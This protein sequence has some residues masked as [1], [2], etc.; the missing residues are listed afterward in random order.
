MSDAG[1]SRSS[2]TLLGNV[3]APMS[4]RFRHRDLELNA[5]C[6]LLMNVEASAAGPYQRRPHPTKACIRPTIN[7]R[8]RRIYSGALPAMCGLPNRTIRAP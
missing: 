6:R 3:R 2:T 1:D 7:L 5:A 4:G 8:R